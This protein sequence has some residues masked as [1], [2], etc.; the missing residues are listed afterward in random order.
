MKGI[1]VLGLFLLTST[2]LMA[3]NPIIGQWNTG[4]EHTIIEVI[5][6][7]GKIEGRIVE[8]ANAKV[9]IGRCIFKDLYS[10]PAGVK[11]KLYSLRKHKWFE[12]TL[13]PSSNQMKITITTGLAKRTVVWKRKE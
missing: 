3:Q 1:S 13:Y 11:G 8:S 12:A 6:I 10:H 7:E 9:P 2:S 5:E 4:Q